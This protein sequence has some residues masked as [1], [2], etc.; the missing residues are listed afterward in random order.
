MNFM[1]KGILV[2]ALLIL[3]IGGYFLIGSKPKEPITSENAQPVV[4]ETFTTEE[5]E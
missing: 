5:S 4:E 1:N 2:T 3:L